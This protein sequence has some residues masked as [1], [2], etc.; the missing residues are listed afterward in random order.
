MRKLRREE[1]EWDAD[2]HRLGGFSLIT[3]AA[4]N[5]MT[6]CDRSPT[7]P[8]QSVESAFIRVLFV[9]PFCCGSSGSLSRGY[10]VMPKSLIVSNVVSW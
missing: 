7:H 3:L 1:K 5:G 10:L 4:P 8:R 6:E 2:F 9:E